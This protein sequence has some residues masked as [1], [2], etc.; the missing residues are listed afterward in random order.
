MLLLL[1]L[2]LLRAWASSLLPS[3]RERRGA[4]RRGAGGCLIFC[5]WSY[6]TRWRAPCQL[7]ASSDFPLARA[8]ARAWRWAESPCPRGSRR[9]VVFS[10]L[11]Y[12]AGVVGSSGR[13]GVLRGVGRDGCGHAKPWYGLHRRKTLTSAKNCGVFWHF[14]NLELQGANEASCSGSHHSSALSSW[15]FQMAEED[16]DYDHLELIDVR[17]SL[18]CGAADGQELCFHS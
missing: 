3:R 17:Q 14:F 10:T 16:V 13:C 8:G 7:P 12:V 9:V 6:A 2:L 4:G 18:F 11:G 5:G 1:V 15:P